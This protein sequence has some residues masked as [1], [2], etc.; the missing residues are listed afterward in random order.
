MSDPQ[1]FISS[2][3]SRVDPID[4][5]LC[6]TF[7]QYANTG[8]EALQG[9]LVELEM[10]SHGIYSNKDDY[11]RIRDWR[12]SAGFD[13]DTA[14]Q[15]DLLYYSFLVNQESE[16]LARKQSELS[17]LISGH[18]S[19]FRGEA[20]GRKL[21]NNDI[22]DLLKEGTDNEERRA[23]WEASKQIG[24]TVAPLILELVRAR[25]ESARLLGFRDYY[26]RQM[27]AQEIAEDELYAILGKLEQLTREPF[28]RLKGELDAKLVERFG[29]KSADE[30]RPWHYEDPFFQEA[31]RI[32][33]L[34]L[35]PY[36]KGK[37]LE[38][39]TVE[40]FDRVGLDI[41]RSLQISDLY[42]REG[43]DQHAFCLGVGRDPERVHVLC[44]CRDNANWAGTMLHEYGHAAYDLLIPKTTPYFLRSIAHISS[45]EAIA[46]LFGRL[47]HDATW[48]EDVLG[49]SA[50]EA[51]GLAAQAQ[52][53][54]SFGMLVFTRW[55]MVMTNFERAL[56]ADPEQDLNTLWWDL[57]E[58]YQEVRRPD[59]RDMPDW[60]C[61]THIAESPVYYHNYML[62]E[63]TASQIQHYIEHELGSAPLIRQPMA[64]PW[65][66]EKLFAQGAR[67]PWNEAL[68]FL[69]G[70][71]LNPE[72]FVSEF[73]RDNAPAAA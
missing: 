72:Y 6:E 36:F 66:Q 67:R 16:E 14:R 33:D 1:T 10:Q 59:G 3:E 40:T 11:E 71:K 43:K 55:M 31:P 64:G 34:D 2:L 22:K 9:K 70:E 38:Q 61:K 23:V 37:D 56:Y 21:T 63:M 30:L 73:V 27:E 51:Q 46:M 7:W 68:E 54:L 41:R 18:F 32:N 26:A 20:L 57:V 35:D 69:T 13:Q 58:R 25:N 50:H 44:N 53:Q 4:T 39:L 15:V 42:E 52:Q 48:L 17:V 47:T 29:L 19:N 65:L 45:T 12:G 62:G 28:H 60:A 49:L 8:D 24:P 5:A